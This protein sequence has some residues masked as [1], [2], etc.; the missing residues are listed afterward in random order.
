M[1]DIIPQKVLGHFAIRTIEDLSRLSN[2]LAKSG[3]FSD[4]K[5]AAQC[6]VKVLAG[7]E[8]GF[9]TIASMCGIHII[10]GKPTLG[11][12]LMAAA[13]K[14]SGK[15]NYRVTQHDN[16]GCVIAFSENGEMVG[17]SSFTKQDAVAAGALDGKNAHTW[18]KFPRNM[19]FARAM[20]NGVRWYCPDIFT[21]TTVYTPDELDEA[22][23]EEGNLVKSV[24]VK[25]TVVEPPVETA[26]KLAPNGNGH[27]HNQRVKEIRTLLGIEGKAVLEWLKTEM[28]VNSPAEL[29]T[30]Q[31]DELIQWMGVQWAAKQGMQHNH[32]LNSLKAHIP[33]IILEGY[34]EVDAIGLWMEHVQQQAAQKQ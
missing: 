30:Q 16:N 33:A 21:G 32:A 25:A 10:N 6:G 17:E 4:S 20:S 28:L 13:V 34:T 29:E 23:D 19:M 11:A 2:M 8:L 24:S 9:P 3:Y 14:R 18:K 27:P 15:Y 7:L 31:V 12:H 1:S 26:S 5:E 22:T